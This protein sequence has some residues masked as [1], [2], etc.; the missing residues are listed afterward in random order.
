MVK[1]LAAELWVNHAVLGGQRKS[2]SPSRCVRRDC[3]S[4]TEGVP[5][6]PAP[7]HRLCCGD[8]VFVGSFNEGSGIFRHG[9]FTPSRLLVQSGD[10][11]GDITLGPIFSGL[12]IN[13]PGTLVFNNGWRRTNHFPQL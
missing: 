9:I 6:I 11:I 12:A 13:D 3:T 10:T 1:L 8:I 4:A 7:H 5:G 2:S